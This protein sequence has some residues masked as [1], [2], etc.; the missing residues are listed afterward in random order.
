MG[1]A[2][3][4]EVESENNL[5]DSDTCRR[6]DVLMTSQDPRAARDRSI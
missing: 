1:T 3:H 2:Q 6:H 5:E 4:E